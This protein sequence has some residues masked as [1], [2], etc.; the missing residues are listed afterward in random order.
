[1]NTVEPGKNKIE[2]VVRVA[3]V[4]GEKEGTVPPRYNY[5][6]YVDLAGYRLKI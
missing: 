3:V 5:I 1:M 4:R 2:T 6:L